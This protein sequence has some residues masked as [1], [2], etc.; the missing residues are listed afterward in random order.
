MRGGAAQ[1]RGLMPSYIEARIE[2]AIETVRYALADVGS[3]CAITA[4][5]SRA[6]DAAVKT[7]ENCVWELRMLLFNEYGAGHPLHQGAPDVQEDYEE[8]CMRWID[9]EE[10][11]GDY[12]GDDGELRVP[13]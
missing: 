7:L 5:D 11:I 2:D 9:E 6:K 8:K 13:V 4:A 1:K 10:G 3:D 12:F